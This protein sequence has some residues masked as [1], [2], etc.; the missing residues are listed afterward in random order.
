MSSLSHLLLFC[1]WSGY[2]MSRSQR[3]LAKS[4]KK[5][6]EKSRRRN[7]L[8]SPLLLSVTHIMRMSHSGYPCSEQAH[9]S[10][11]Y[12]PETQKQEGDH[13]AAACRGWPVHCEIA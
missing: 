3:E 1:G 13:E 7:M 11:T 8:A 5:K 2:K 9:K 10:P 4:V 6:N 12:A